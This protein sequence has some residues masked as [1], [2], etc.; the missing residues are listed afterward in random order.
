MYD[1][2]VHGIYTRCGALTQLVPTTPGG[3]DAKAQPSERAM[4]VRV[5]PPVA[6]LA[7]P[8]SECTEDNGQHQIGSRW[9]LAA[10][11]IGVRERCQ[12][13]SRHGLAHRPRQMIGWPLGVEL[14][15]GR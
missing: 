11:S 1:V 14:A 6:G 10:A 9:R 4:L 15:P 13:T 8:P 5:L 2:H 7:L 3:T 12:I